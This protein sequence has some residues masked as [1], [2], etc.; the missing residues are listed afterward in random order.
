LLGAIFARRPRSQI[1]CTWVD[2]APQGLFNVFT[3]AGRAGV[4]EDAL[5]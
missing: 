3:Y 1:F 2:L 4:G 5:D